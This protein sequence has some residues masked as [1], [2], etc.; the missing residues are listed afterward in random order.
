M[1][2]E[3]SMNVVQGLSPGALSLRFRAEA[4]E[5]ERVKGTEKEYPVRNEDR[6]KG[7]REEIDGWMDG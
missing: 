1:R 5:K 6:E 2:S 4:S 3:H 7:G